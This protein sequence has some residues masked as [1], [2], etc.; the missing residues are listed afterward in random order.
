[1]LL[2]NHVFAWVIFG[3]FVVLEQFQ[4]QNPLFFFFFFFSVWVERKLVIFA[5]LVK[6]G[7]P[8]GGCFDQGLFSKIASHGFRGFRGSSKYWNLLSA[9]FKGII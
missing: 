4:E 2:V 5:V 8:K 9:I 6:S 7:A 1:M 3:I